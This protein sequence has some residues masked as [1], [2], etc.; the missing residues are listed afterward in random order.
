MEAYKGHRSQMRSILCD[1]AHCITWKKNTSQHKVAKSSNNYSSLAMH[2]TP[3]K[4]PS[5]STYEKETRQMR[6]IYSS[7]LMHTALQNAAQTSVNAS[8]TCKFRGAAYQRDRQSTGKPN[9]ASNSTSSSSCHTWCSKEK[10]CGS[11]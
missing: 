7:L 8:R 9:L 2:T 3:R 11:R 1:R 10:R 5:V 6:R 4:K